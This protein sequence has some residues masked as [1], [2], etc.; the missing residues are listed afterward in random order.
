MRYILF[1]L[2]IVCTLS[3]WAEAPIMGWSSWNTYRVNISDSLIMVQAEAMKGLGLDT[4]G[5]KYIN[6]DDGY[7][8]G[9]DRKS[10]QLKIHS[11]R[12]P[13]G[14][15]PVVDY[16]H[17]LGLKAGIYSDAGM[18]TC[19][20]FWDNDT[21]AEC[22]GLYGHERGDC[23]FFFKKLGFD[24]IKVD[25]CGGDSAQNKQHLSL[26]PQERYTYIRTVIDS[27]GRSDVKMNVCR[28]DF[29][30]TWVKDVATS[31]RISQDINNNWWSIKDIIK[32]NLYLSAYASKGHY[33]DMDMLELGRTLTPEEERTH[34]GM[35]CMLSSPLLIGCNLLSIPQHS[36]DLLRNKY[37]I[38]IN[39]DSLGLQAEVAY[40]YSG[41]YIL[42]KDV[43]NLHGNKRAIAVY[44]PL[45]TTVLAMLDMDKL[46]LKYPVRMTDVYGDNPI[47]TIDAPLEVSVSPHN[48][49]IFIA[50]GKGTVMKQ[51]YEAETGYLTAYN[52]INGGVDSPK[53]VEAPEC[54]GEM[55]VSGLGAS[56]TN[57]II[58][59]DI[60][61]VDS[62]QYLISIRYRNSGGGIIKLD[63]NDNVSHEIALVPTENWRS[64]NVPVSL[65]KGSNR[66]RLFA[67]VSIFDIDYVEIN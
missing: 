3:L 65:T 25:F 41:A 59:R 19:G 58:W 61:V 8:G 31:W 50:E 14:L 51:R 43:E 38:A 21:I 15:K 55:C 56:V 13:K 42:V 28:W 23:D 9:R 46:G 45:D 57:D 47:E 49:M 10:G 54:S 5:Y 30:G 29:P 35:W 1:L 32:Q 67:H 27:I 36:L 48:T 16:I 64:V 66:I 53:Y 18:N 39:Q 7:F 11:Q 62:G 33:N 26:D 22:V 40:K 12:F 63:I 6:I 37:L 2:S 34:F 52:E 4:L 20:N 60:Y 44:N 24:F 17:S